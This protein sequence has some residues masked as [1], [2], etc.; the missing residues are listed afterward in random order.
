MSIKAGFLEF[1]K[2]STVEGGARSTSGIVTGGSLSDET[3]LSRINSVGDWRAK[4]LREQML[5]PSGTINLSVQEAGLLLLAQRSASGILTS[6]DIEG[7]VD[8]WSRIYHACKI[9]TVSLDC[10]AGEELR[11]TV[12]FKSLYSSA[13]VG[14]I[15][16]PSSD[17]I[18]K[19]FEGKLQ[20]ISGELLSASISISN[21]VDYVPVIDNALDPKRRAKYLREGELGVTATL[22]FAE[23]NSV[24][25]MAAAISYISSVTLTFTG[26]NTVTIT[27][28]NLKPR[29]KDLP[30]T[31][32]DLIENGVEYECRDWSIS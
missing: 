17:P 2:H 6:F 15:H 16:S 13:G 26:T 18:L 27:L 3:V 21:N 30:L 19:W 23:A 4:Q 5:Q 24:D 25:I 32:M 28:T 14:S 10:T 12:G 11:A 9:D 31:P 7:G 22:K 20:G 1:V 8:D 29:L